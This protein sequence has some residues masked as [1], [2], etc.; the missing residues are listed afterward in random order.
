MAPG[1]LGFLKNFLDFLQDP[2]RIS[3]HFLKDVIRSLNDFTSDSE[4]SGF[5]A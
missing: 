2:L 1:F 4:A 3:L 5:R